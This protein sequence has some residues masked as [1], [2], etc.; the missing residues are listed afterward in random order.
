LGWW[1]TMRLLERVFSKHRV[2]GADVV[3]LSAQGDIASDF[4][5]ARLAAKLAALALRT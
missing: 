4:A 3:E 2:V 1:E 5:A